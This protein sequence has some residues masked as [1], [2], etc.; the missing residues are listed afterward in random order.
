LLKASTNMIKVKNQVLSSSNLRS[1]P[2][3][4]EF[5][6]DAVLILKDNGQKVHIPVK[7]WVYATLNQTTCIF[8][9]K[10]N[11]KTFRLFTK[12]YTLYTQDFGIVDSYPTRVFEGYKHIAKASNFSALKSVP[13]KFYDE[14]TLNKILTD[15]DFVGNAYG[16]DK[17]WYLSDI[18]LVDSHTFVFPPNSN[19]TPIFYYT[20]KL[21]MKRAGFYQS[22][23]DKYDYG[24]LVE[25]IDVKVEASVNA[26]SFYIKY[27]KSMIWVNLGRRG[28]AVPKF[29]FPIKK[30]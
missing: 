26:R 7:T 25:G 13:H 1:T 9:L 6:Y 12:N 8:H 3:P 14:H 15:Y 16:M 5:Y 18:K 24:F 27:G 28:L 23:E 21:A 4:N 17:M 19:T 29:P 10:N 22:M 30:A 11:M 20:A 2:K